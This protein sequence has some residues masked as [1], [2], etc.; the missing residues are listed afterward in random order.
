MNIPEQLRDLADGLDGWELRTFDPLA[1]HCQVQ[2]YGRAPWVLTP[3]EFRAAEANRES[4]FIEY[5]ICRAGVLLSKTFAMGL[6]DGMQFFELHTY[7][8]AICKQDSDQPST[9]NW[10]SFFYGAVAA[11]IDL[12]DSGMMTGQ[13]FKRPPWAPAIGD[14]PVPQFQASTAIRNWW[15]NAIIEVATLIDNAIAQRKDECVTI[16]HQQLTNVF[17]RLLIESMQGANVSREAD[18]LTPEV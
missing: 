6:F 8:R 5:H 10:S 7:W 15:R 12:Q 11:F 2:V 3:D 1:D 14:L 18:P 4:K 9:D 16:T 17:Q 13:A